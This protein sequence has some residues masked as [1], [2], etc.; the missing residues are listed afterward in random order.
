M[1]DQNPDASA[2][3]AVDPVLKVVTA[4]I[5]ISAPA[6]AV[7]ELIADPQ[8]QPEWDGNDNLGSAV[9]GQRMHGTG[10]SFITTLTKGV[11]RENHIVDFEEGRRIAWKPSEVAGEPFGQKWVWEI[12]PV[13]DD[14]VLVR[15]IYDW[16][17]LRDPQRLSRAQS[18]TAANLLASLKRLKQLAES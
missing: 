1:T 14:S 5:E 4:E 7:F 17:E 16:T 11:D 18:T 8:R 13:G 6:E 15:H 10:G 12:E 2:F 3:D 9:E